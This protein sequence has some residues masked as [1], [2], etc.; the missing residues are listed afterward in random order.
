MWN[1]YAAAVSKSRHALAL[2]PTQRA[3]RLDGKSKMN[4]SNLVIHGL[5]AMSVH[6]DTIRVRLLVATSLLI[7][8]TLAGLVC[9]AAVRLV[10]DSAIPGWATFAAGTLL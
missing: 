7:G 1:H 3:Q 9:I 6:G 5:S 2:V 10:T 4:Y 8:L